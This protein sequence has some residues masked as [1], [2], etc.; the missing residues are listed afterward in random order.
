MFSRK[1]YIEIVF[2]IQIN[3]IKL[4][5]CLAFIIV[6]NIYFNYLEYYIYQ[7]SKNYYIFINDKKYFQKISN[8]YIKIIFF[9]VTSSIKET[10]KHFVINILIKKFKET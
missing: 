2:L 9:Y 10:K 7:F 6:F 4:N 3:I 1:W 8:T 5:F